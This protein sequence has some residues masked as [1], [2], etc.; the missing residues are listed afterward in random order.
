MIDVQ[1][2]ARITAMRHKLSLDAYHGNF[3]GIKFD[4]EYANTMINR[5]KGS[6]VPQG[7]AR[8]VELS[9]SE[10]PSLSLSERLYANPS[11]RSA[12]RT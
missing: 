5:Q 12:A 8:K 11:F 7:H 4:I 9:R 1:L 2:K 6:I 10:E 3:E